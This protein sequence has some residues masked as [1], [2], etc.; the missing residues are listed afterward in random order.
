MFGIWGFGLRK[1]NRNNYTAHKNT[2]SGRVFG[3]V[4]VDVLAS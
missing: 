1:N 2:L 4:I 3:W